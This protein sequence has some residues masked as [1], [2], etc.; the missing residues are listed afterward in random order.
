MEGFA[1]GGA[2]AGLDVELRGYAVVEDELNP[3]VMVV[4]MEVC[5]PKVVHCIH[6]VQMSRVVGSREGVLDQLSYVR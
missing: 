6:A 3:H 5:R 2:V 4:T 1:G